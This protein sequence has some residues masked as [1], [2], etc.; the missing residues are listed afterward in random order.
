[1]QLYNNFWIPWQ[2]AELI[3]LRAYVYRTDKLCE[4]KN[5]KK[6][7]KLSDVIPSEQACNMI[8][9][10]LPTVIPNRVRGRSLNEL[11][12]Y[13]FKRVG[14][15]KH[16]YHILKRIKT[17]NQLAKIPASK[18]FY[19]KKDLEEFKKKRDSKRT[20]AKA[21]I[22]E[23]FKEDHALVGYNPWLGPQE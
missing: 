10:N 7:Y 8:E 4:I 22:N 5:H 1:M 23:I 18:I 15:H 20:V 21:F 11:D 13:F 2:E 6:R 12:A 9:Y 17:N 16:Q 3:I 19:L 14:H